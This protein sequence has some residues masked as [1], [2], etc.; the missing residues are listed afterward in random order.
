MIKLVLDLRRESTPQTFA[1]YQPEARKFFNAQ[2]IQGQVV[3][4]EVKV[5]A[6]EKDKYDLYIMEN[7]LMA[8]GAKAVEFHYNEYERS[9]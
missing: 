3:L 6:G 9:D 7:H 2:K 4:V 5:Y 8:R 1:E